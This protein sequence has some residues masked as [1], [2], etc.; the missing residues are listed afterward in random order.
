MFIQDGIILRLQAINRSKVLV[1]FAFVTILLLMPALVSAQEK[2]A[3]QS[4]R[5]GNPEIYIMD[6]NGA[7]QLRLTVNSVFDG[8]PAFSRTGEKIAFSSARDGNQE[9]YIMHADG[10]SQTR[11]T[12]SAGADAHPAFSPDGT[13]IVFVSERSG[14]LG[15]WVMNVDGS[16]PVELMDGFGGTEPEFSPNGTKIVFCGTGGGGG[17]SQIWTMNADG[18]GR[19]NLSKSVNSDDTSP[20]FSPD[21]TKIVYFRNPHGPGSGT[22]EINV[23]NPDGSNQV[24]ITS[25][26]GKDFQPSY[27]VDG[28]RI[29]FT[30]LATGAAEIYAMN[31]DGTSPIN[32]TNHF[33]SD[34]V[35]VWG[36]MNSAPV[37]NNVA[38]SSPINEGG[39]ATLTGQ[40]SDA[41]LNDSFVLTVSW[42][43]GQSQTVDYPAGT[44]SFELTHLYTDDPAA[45]APSDDYVI[46]CNINDHRF[47]TDSSSTSVTVNNVSPTLSN[48]SVSPSTVAVGA[49]VTLSGNYADPGYHGS[50]AD[51][52]LQVFVTWGDGQS[53]SVVT[54]GAPGALNET[55]Q[56]AAAGTYTITVQATD[57]DG[58]VTVETRSLVVTMS[59]PATPT[60]FKVQSVAVNRV[61]LIWTDASN[62]EAGFAIERCSAKRA[63]TNFVEVGRVGANVTTYLDNTVTGAT[64]YFYRMR[65]FNS[66]GTS[67]YTGVVSTKTPRK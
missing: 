11:L 44:I 27:S 41:N 10:S 37:L 50:A 42:G 1:V 46:T 33:G 24:P 67:N 47:G 16:N 28:T 35:A 53:T 29:V 2:I 17:N 14:H 31:V 57:N 3:F 23:M 7:N 59:P 22:A 39:V 15:I 34:L 43:D 8:D 5:D 60:G 30:S 65:G 4:Q 36:A 61:T 62:N 21:G 54:N 64:Q 25:S 6:A 45:G 52:Q 56:Y 26:N 51:E 66:G 20:S 12:N 32:L 49:T 9:I 55:H 40:I 18:T 58:G 38:V 19:D 63:C 48:I 13:K